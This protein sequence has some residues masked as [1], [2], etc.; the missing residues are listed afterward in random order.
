MAIENKYVKL[1]HREQILLRPDTYIGSIHNEDREYWAFNN[2]KIELVSG[3][4]NPG[5]IKMY[6]EILTNASDHSIRTGKVSHIKITVNTDSISVENDGPGIPIVMHEKEKVYIPEL[7]FGHL[8]TSEN[9]DD[10]MERF[11]GGRNGY[12][13]KLTAIFSTKFVVETCD[14]KKKYIQD[15]DNNLLTL[16]KPKITASKKS[17][18]KITYYP[19]FAKFGMVENTESIVNILHKRAADI[20]AYNPKVDVYFNDVKLNVRKFDDYIK[21]YGIEEVFYAKIS[22]NWEIAVTN[23]TNTQVSL[24]NG[25]STNSGGTH[26]TYIN[27]LIANEI[28]TYLYKKI[29]GCTL[30]LNEI[31]S[32]FMVFL[33]CKIANPTFD[34][35]SKETLTTKITAEITKEFNITDAFIKR[36]FKS[37]IVESILDWYD[38]KQNADANKLARDVNKNLSKIKVDKLI[39]AKGDGKDRSKCTLALFE[40]DSASSPFRD[41]RNQNTQ[42]AFC[43]KGKFVNATDMSNQ[44]LVENAEVLNFMAAMGLRLGE[45]A[46]KDKLRYGK[47]LIYTDADTDGSCI[48]A[49]LLNFIFRYWPELFDFKM[50]YRVETPLVVTINIK[51][52]KKISFYHQEDYNKWI[53]DVNPKEWIIEY[54]KGLAA[55][56]DDEYKDIILNPRLLLFTIDDNS[57][58]SLNIWFG[59]DSEP[60]KKELLKLQ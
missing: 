47:V 20:A 27:N 3:I 38:Q 41:Y 30:T 15:F 37:T 55:L 7:I 53:T 58:D 28:K 25:I 42:G 10:S 18:T 36:I 48:A 33:C 46:D 22:E 59:D 6:D 26:V 4:Y 13:A 60:R 16:N 5:Y 35:Q 40:G 2:D 44:E 51:S 56:G 21:L 43:L 32:K 57:K 8:L 50:V 9:Y 12:G 49:L 45:K 24:V 52:K 31:R 17:Y 34:T 19:D 23:G 29:K 11:T 1:T 39:D 54:K 14:G